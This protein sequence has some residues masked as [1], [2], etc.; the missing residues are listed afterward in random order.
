MRPPLMLVHD[1]EQLE[2]VAVPDSALK[3]PDVAPEQESHIFPGASRRD[4][5]YREISQLGPDAAPW[6]E[7]D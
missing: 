7:R 6:V 5:V 4:W 2:R 1:P 3:A